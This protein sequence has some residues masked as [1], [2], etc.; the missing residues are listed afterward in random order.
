MQLERKLRLSNYTSSVQFSSDYQQITQRSKLNSK[1][2]TFRDQSPKGS[3]RQ[4]KNIRNRNEEYINTF[5]SRSRSNS[6]KRNN[7]KQQSSVV[8]PL[9]K[10]NYVPEIPPIVFSKVKQIFE[11]Q[12]LQKHKSM[13]SFTHSS[14]SQSINSNQQ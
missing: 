13:T 6:N 11:N 12:M 1:E 4:S 9:K 2:V 8:Q 14:S 3:I 5:Q 10:N 7:E